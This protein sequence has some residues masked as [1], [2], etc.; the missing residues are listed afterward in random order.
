MTDARVSGLTAV[1]TE[2]FGTLEP[3]ADASIHVIRKNEMHG[4]DVPTVNVPS[5]I[6]V[7][8]DGL[9]GW[10]VSIPERVHARI[11]KDVER[12]PGAE[13][14]GVIGVCASMVTRRIVVTDI[15][16]APPDSKRTASSFV[17]GTSCLEA[18]L[19]KIEADSSGVLRRLGTWHSHLGGAEP[20]AIDW[21]AAG[22]VA[23]GTDGPMVLLIKG[24]DGFRAISRSPEL[25]EIKAEQSNGDQ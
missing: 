1:K 7:Q 24:N 13:S 8:I 18:R 6:R 4:L 16:D 10:P 17:L 14:G 25:P 19:S 11:C 23:T 22:I 12:Y 15:V 2:V 20:S 21:E 9:E 3:G 5:F